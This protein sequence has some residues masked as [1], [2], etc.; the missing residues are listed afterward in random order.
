[1]TEPN[2][3]LICPVSGK[4]PMSQERMLDSLRDCGGAV[5]VR[6]EVDTKLEGAVAPLNRAAALECRDC[7]LIGFIGEDVVVRTCGWV[8]A[9][10]DAWSEGARVIY[11]NDLCSTP[12]LP[13][14]VVMDSRIVGALGWMAPPCLRHCFADNFW[15]ELGLRLGALRYLPDV[16]WE[17]FHPLAGKAEPDDCYRRVYSPEWLDH[18]YLAW[19]RYA[20]VQ[21][22]RD[23]QL[24][25]AALKATL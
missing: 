10:T 5:K 21:L 13:T 18:D 9:V 16:I 19:S 20:T 24:V 17:H 3:T 2:I 11:P 14:H 25:R 7:D 8:G 12:A 23:L 4:R 6:L 22:N 15:R 1:M